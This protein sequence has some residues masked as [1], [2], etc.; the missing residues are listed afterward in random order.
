M[1]IEHSA[2]A[3]GLLLCFQVA[4]SAQ[5]PK[6]VEESGHLSPVLVKIVFLN[7]TS[8]TVMLRGICSA[9]GLVGSIPTHSLTVRTDGGASERSIWL[10][11]IAAIEGTGTMRTRG[12][13]FTVVMKDGKKVAAQFTGFACKGQISLDSPEYDCRTLYTYND[14][15]GN[16]TID[17]QKVKSVQFLGPARKDK[18]GNALFETWPYS[19][20]TGEK[21]PQ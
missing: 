19:P 1:R 10:D 5:Q 6:V 21:V 8:R 11:S 16:Q 4:L 2:V 17:L 15:D 14:D 18:V 9:P 20:F 3:F 7:D 13:D 12:S